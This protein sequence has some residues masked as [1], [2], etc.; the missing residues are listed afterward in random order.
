MLFSS[1][2]GRLVCLIVTLSL[3]PTAIAGGASGVYEQVGPI[4]QTYR[5]AVQTWGKDKK[6]ILPGIPGNSHPLGGA[7]FLEMIKYLDIAVVKSTFKAS[8]TNLN[9]PDPHAVVDYARN[10]ATSDE[11][12]SFFKDTPLPKIIVGSSKYFSEF[13]GQITTIVDSGT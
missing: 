5:I 10:K 11:R 1:L 4:Y 8:V 13:L 2:F 12:K 3:L 9:D 6:K 7:N